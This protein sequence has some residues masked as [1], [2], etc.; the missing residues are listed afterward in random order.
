MKLFLTIFLFVQG[1]LHVW[2][3]PNVTASLNESAVETEADLMMTTIP[4]YPTASMVRVKSKHIS[5]GLRT[6]LQNVGYIGWENGELY[7]DQQTN[8]YALRIYVATPPVKVSADTD[9]PNPAASSTSN[10]YFFT[11]EGKLFHYENQ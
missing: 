6:T 10:W 2:A 1:F 4:T 8:D 9:Q 3:Q 7:R 11:S 5:E